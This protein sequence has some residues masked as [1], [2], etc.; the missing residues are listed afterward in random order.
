M[1]HGE[2]LAA[3][4]PRFFSTRN[5]MMEKDFDDGFSVASEAYNTPAT[6]YYLNRPVLKNIL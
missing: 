3:A 6:S 4:V 1:L 5:R 2:L